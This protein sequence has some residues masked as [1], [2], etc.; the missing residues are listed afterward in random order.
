MHG[1]FPFF[2]NPLVQRITVANRFFGGKYFMHITFANCSEGDWY[3]CVQLYHLPRLLVVNL[4]MS[5]GPNNIISDLI[6][7]SVHNITH[8]F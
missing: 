3:T 7:T 5:V 2:T 6:Y 8:V 1:I 4:M